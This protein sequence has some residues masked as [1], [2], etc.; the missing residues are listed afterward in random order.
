MRVKYIEFLG[1]KD[2]QNGVI[3]FLDEN[4]EP[5]QKGIYKL[6]R[7]GF[8]VIYKELGEWLKNT[9]AT[10]EVTIAIEV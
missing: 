2:G 9:Q 3:T 10:E 7:F 5:V 4:K 6:N 1:G 8:E